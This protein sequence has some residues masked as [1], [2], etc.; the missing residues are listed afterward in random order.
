[1]ASPKKGSSATKLII[2]RQP[3]KTTIGCSRNTHFKS[4]HDKRNK[5]KYRGQGK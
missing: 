4:K 5:K 3:K 1:M 2:E